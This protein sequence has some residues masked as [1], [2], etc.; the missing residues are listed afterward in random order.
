MRVGSIVFATQQ[1]LGILAKSFYDAGI[2]QEVLVIR[3]SRRP[4]YAEWYPNLFRGRIGSHT[5]EKTFHDFIDRT[6]IDVL[7]MFETPF[8]WEVIPYARRRGVKTVMMPMYEC[9]PKELP[10]VPDRYICPS[11]LDLQY[12]PDNSVFLPVPVDET[13]WRYRERARVF[14]HNAGHGGLR[15]RNGTKEL[16]DAIPLTTCPAEFQIRSQKP[17]SLPAALARDSRVKLEVGT[18]NSD[19][20]YATG[21]VFIFPEKFNGLSLPLQEA[22]ASGMLVMSTNRFPINTWLPV[23]PLL[24]VA[25]YRTASVS[26]RCVDFPEAVLDPVAIARHIDDWYDRDISSYSLSGKEW[27]QQNSWEILKPKYLEALAL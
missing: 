24:P 14:V 15:G 23:E 5:D 21:D 3:H 4:D 19:S 8:H 6:G 22:F 25:S 27:A 2:I 10:Y 11:L 18:V 26:L 12:F 17:L 13:E 16:L 7:L 1:G 9:M 20:L